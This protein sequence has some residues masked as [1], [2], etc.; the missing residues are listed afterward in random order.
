MRRA[1]LVILSL[2]AV[3]CGSPQDTWAAWKVLRAACRIVDSWE[4]P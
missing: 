2:Y 3:G 1:L 4:A